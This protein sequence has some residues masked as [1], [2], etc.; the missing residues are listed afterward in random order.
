NRAGVRGPATHDP[1]QLRRDGIGDA[2]SG[3][4]GRAFKMAFAKFATNSWGVAASVTKGIYFEGDAGMQL[5]PA[6]ITDNAFNQGF[7]GPADPG[8]IEAPT[9][10][11]VGRD[12][13]DD[14]QYIWEA[15]AMGS[16]TAVVI[17]TSAAG[18]TTSWTHQFDLADQID[19]LGVTVAIDKNLYVEELPSAKVHGMEETQADN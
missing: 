10:N 11:L 2:M 17:S 16:P 19:G 3:Q 1:G 14:F 7:L 9:L 12:R 15:L 13:Y 8:M 5:K 6:E 18:Q 4:T